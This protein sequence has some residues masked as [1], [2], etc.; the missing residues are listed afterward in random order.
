MNADIKGALEQINKSWKA[1]EHDGK[2]MTKEQVRAC[3]TYGLSRGYEH[4]GQLTDDDIRL[5]LG[6]GDS[7]KEPEIIKPNQDQTILNF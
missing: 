7:L 2:P 4:T 3:L 1:F 5:V 6:N